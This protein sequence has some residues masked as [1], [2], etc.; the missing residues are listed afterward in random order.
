[1]GFF[2]LS[3]GF[4]IFR[5]SQDDERYPGKNTALIA[6]LVAIVTGLLVV[7]RRFTGQWV[8]ED[9]FLFVLGTVI[10]VTGLAHMFSEYRIGGITTNRQTGIHFILSLFEVLL[11]G[12]LILSPRM[13]RPFVYWAATA[14]ALIYGVM[15]LGMAVHQYVQSRQEETGP[16]TGSQSGSESAQKPG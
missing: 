5:R 14:W 9:V 11:G 1:M 2:W 13:S 16:Q 12:L 10:L 3:I 7:T 15:S 8:A 4:A 6:G